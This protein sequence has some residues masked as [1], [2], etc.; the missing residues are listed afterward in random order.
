VPG[1]HRRSSHHDRL[2]LR[3]LFRP[4]IVKISLDSEEALLRREAADG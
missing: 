3:L 1:W 4:D 2:D